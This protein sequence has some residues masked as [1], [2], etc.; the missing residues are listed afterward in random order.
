MEE[1]NKEDN[2]PLSVLQQANAAKKELALENERMEKN[3]AEM[4][5]LQATNMLS[6]NIDAG[7]P[8]EPPKEETAKEY[9]DRVMSGK[10]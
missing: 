1:E 4:R 3:M 6:G 5:E 10:L 8:E 7:K 9:K 2:K